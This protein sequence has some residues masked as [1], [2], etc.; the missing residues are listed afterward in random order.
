MSLFC[1]NYDIVIVGGGISGLFI[2]YKLC[3]TNLNI[4]LIEKSSSLGGRIHTIYNKK[5]D[6]QYECGAAR[7]NENH[8]KLLSLIHEF[9]LESKMY[10]LS[11][12]LTKVTR[13][14][15][16]KYRLN[17]NY[18]LDVLKKSY[19]RYPRSYLQNINLYQLLVDI[20][21][22]ETAEFIKDSFG[23]DSEFIHLNADAALIM[24][25]HDLFSNNDYYIL[26]GGLSEIIF[27]MEQFLKNKSNITILKNNT[28]K[29]IFNDKIETSIDTYYYKRLI[30]AIPQFNLKQLD[31][32]KDFKLLDSVKPIH[33]LRIYATY[34]V[35]KDGPWFKDIKRTTTDNYLRHIIPVDYKK[36][37]IMISYT[38][39][40]PADM[41]AN[42]YQNSKKSLE[43][44]IH[45]E[46]KTI[47]KITPPDMINMY[48]HSWDNEYTGVH[49]WKP[50]E[51]ILNLYEKILQPDLN[52]EIYI[53]G[54][55]YSKKQ[56]WIEGALQTSYDVIKRLHL[57]DIFI[58]ISNPDDDI[59]ITEEINDP[60]IHIDKVLQNKTWIA[61]EFGSIV[62]V[63]DIKDWISDHPG[64]NIILE[65]IK[66]NIYYKDGNGKSPIEM[67]RNIGEYHYKSVK[68]NL[69]NNKN[70]K[71]LGLL[72]Y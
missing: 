16:T 64:G 42:M 71:Y 65:G 70:I 3:E 50:G 29:K 61:I 28:L 12:E 48:V 58:E 17:L 22:N 52:K 34:P 56:C 68:R 69:L 32:F 23:Y 14:Y 67:I 8:H 40:L 19:K 47:F 38:D 13:E 46:I 66:A 4:L 30:L 6:I 35:D 37:L 20:F 9:K 24:F 72:D 21:D 53:C 31:E 45:K 43:E 27:K 1:T 51:D 59:V 41:L 36:G 2:A 39:S 49:M 63:Y 15:K 18:L 5:D 7:F 60:K 44:A 10:T 25:E 57:E 55:A 33:L 26:K 62:K 54:E 11:K